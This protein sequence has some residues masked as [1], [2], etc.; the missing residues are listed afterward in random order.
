MP[1]PKDRPICPHC[2][3]RLRVKPGPRTVAV[4]KWQC[5]ACLATR[6]AK[7]CEWPNG[8]F[9]SQRLYEEDDGE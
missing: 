1:E 5:K 9:I 7:E 3:G 2:K 6:P 4:P 8:W